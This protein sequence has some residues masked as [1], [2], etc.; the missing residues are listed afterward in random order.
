MRM[1]KFYLLILIISLIINKVSGQNVTYTSLNDNV[2]LVRTLNLKTVGSTSGSADVSATGASSYT[3]PIAIPPGTNGIAPSVSLEYNSQSGNGILGMGWG[4]SGLSIIARQTKTIYH[5]GETNPI[6]LNASDRFAMDGAKLFFKAGI[7]Q[8]YG[9]DGN[10]HGIESENFVNVISHGTAGTGPQWFEAQTIDGSFMEFGNTANSSIQSSTGTILAWGISKIRYTDGNYIQFVY[11]NDPQSLRITEI[12]Y[13]GNS[14]TN[15]LPYN[16]I[17]FEYKTGRIDANNQF[18]YGITLNFQHLLDKIT[19]T[20]ELETLT[21]KTYQFAY[22]NDGVNSYLTG[23]SESGSDGTSLNSTIFKYGDKPI[24]FSPSSSAIIQN[25]EG[26][27][28][29]GDFNADGLSDLLETK[30]VVVNN[31]TYH[32]EFTI[33]AKEPTN[34]ADNLFA[35]IG[36]KV[37]PAKTTVIQKKNYP[38]STNFLAHDFNGD[39]TDDILTVKTSIFGGE[40]RLESMKVYTSYKNPSIGYPILFDSTGLNGGTGSTGKINQTTGNFVFA[41]DFNGDGIQ[42]ILTLT[43]WSDGSIGANLHSAVF[44]TT[45]FDKVATTGIVKIPIKDWSSAQQIHILDFNGDGKSDLMIIKNQEC[46]I[47]TFEE[48]TKGYPRAR[49]IFY[50][51]TSVNYQHVIYFG[52]FNGD[53]KTD[54]LARG[55]LVNNTSVPWKKIL[56]TGKGVTEQTFTFHHTPN[57]V[58]GQSDDQLTIGD[59]NGDGKSDIYH[60]WRI[61][62]TTSNLDIYYSQGNSFQFVR[63]PFSGT[64]GNTGAIGSDLNGDGRSDVINRKSYNQPFDIFYFRKEGKENL[65]EKLANGVGHITEWNYKKLTDAGTFYIQGAVSQYPVNNIQPP[66][67]AVYEFKSQN[68]IGGYST[69]QFNYEQARLQLTGKGFLGFQKVTESNLS[70]GIKTVSENQFNPTYF[71]A[72]PYQ[73]TTYLISNSSSPIKQTTF[74]YDFINLSG[75]AISNRRFW[76]RPNNIVQNNNLEGNT[77]TTTYAYETNSAPVYHGNPTRITVNNKVT[78]NDNVIETTVTNTLT[79]VIYGTPNIYKPELIT[80]TNTRS[81]QLAYTTKT[82]YAYNSLGQVTSKKN[83]EGLAAEITTTYTYTDDLGNNL[84]NITSEKV[85]AAGVEDRTTKYVYDAKGRYPESTTNALLQTSN[86]SY[87]PKWGKP[88]TISSVDGLITTY[89][90]DA[91]GRLKITSPSAATAYNITEAYVWNSSNGA[92]WYNLL[93]HPGKPDVKTWYDVLGRKIRTETE[94]YP[95]GSTIIQTQTY[96]ER[97]NINTST[98]PYKSGE[99]IITT[100][101]L[102]DSYNRPYNINKGVLGTTTIDYTYTSGNIKITSTAPTGTSSKTTDATGQVITSSDNAGTLNY[103]YYSH[104]G[105]KDVSNNGTAL[106]SSKYDDYGRH[107]ELIDANAGTT[108]YEYNSLNELIKQTSANGEIYT[109]RYDVLG[110]STERLRSGEP[111]TFYKY[112]SSGAGINQV[113][114]ITGFSGN[115]EDYIYDGYG[116]FQSITETI[117]GSPYIRSFGYNNY[118]DVISTTYP[119]GFGTVHAYDDNGYPTTIK[120]NKPSPTTLYSTE[121][122]NGQGQVSSYSLGNG[123][124]S[125]IIYTNGFP[126]QYL[127]T[128]KQNLNLDWNYQ[129]GNLTS[130]NDAIK[131]LTENFTYDALNRL[132]TTKIG[133]TTLTTNYAANGNITTKPDAGSYSYHTTKFNAVVGVTNPSPSP[134]PLLQQDITYTAFMQPEKVTE[135]G[136]ELTYTYG[137]DYERIKNVTK[138]DNNIINTRYYFDGFEKDVTINTTQYVQYVNSPVGLIC[139]VLNDGSDLSS[140]KYIYNDHLGSILTV[141]D[142][143]GTIITSA[144]QSFDAWGRRRDPNTW[145]LL[146]PTAANALPNWLYRGYTG[147]EHLDNFGLINMNGRMYDPVVGRMLSPDT[148]IQE[149]GMTQSYNRYSYGMNNP[150]I[151]TDPDGHF[152]HIVIGAAVGGVVNLGVKA[153]HGKIHKPKDAFVAFGIGAVAGAVTAA[154]GGAAA[155]ALNL[156]V[157]SIGGGAVAGAAG[158]AT[159]GLIQGVGNA[160]Y[161][162]DKYTPKDW[163]IGIGVGAAA[164]GLGGGIAAWRNGVKT[165]IPKNLW[166]GDDVADGRNI[167]GGFKRIKPEYGNGF[168]SGGNLERVIDPDAISEL[169]TNNNVFASKDNPIYKATVDKYLSEMTDNTFDPVKNAVGGFKAG[170]DFIIREGHHRV[171]AAIIYGMKTNDYSILTQL[172]KQGK[173]TPYTSAYGA[174]NKIKFPTIWK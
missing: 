38:E 29:V 144:Q 161:F 83:F 99:A 52:D 62:S 100:T 106:S 9:G 78:A 31:I 104:G 12:N 85:S 112:F 151:N 159:G 155:G 101:T 156:S 72:S 89:Q 2:S 145:T 110:R 148:Y 68:G 60:G 95:L 141:T 56:S 87:D 98:K 1:K 47:F 140:Y 23:V 70:S 135:N 73:T 139:I 132:E 109:M 39:G 107:I 143:S 169:A 41:G 124:S 10:W 133:T 115:T 45:F 166:N 88:L 8:V 32:T 14:V 152:W 5:D 116:R 75:T 27:E 36:Y 103:S 90:Y 102:Y 160:V 54:M 108:K 164:G 129:T 153:F 134:I 19:V 69:V 33:Y 13:T 86:S 119:S 51:T 76:F 82:K 48:G 130:R 122:V 128:G 170:E 37:L 79:T 30:K 15:L 63:N 121:G 46:E 91:Y 172:I 11:A 96:D 25:V 150:M 171:T 66:L 138:K 18:E 77:V 165:R 123:Q 120:N 174:L 157:A 4:L 158:S 92:V 136:F 93:S 28:Y 43:G 44:N 162:K 84:G 94:G 97:G 58:G 3:I 35:S 125:S 126:T 146:S 34:P 55:S 127:T 59:F 17:K 118:G 20:T 131:S 49:S 40:W 67:Y 61:T 114:K 16:K 26:D 64:I 7:T 173:F 137:A 117:D 147:H 22:G 50:S 21:V 80:I 74:S 6:E 111:T 53:K 65:L 105:L 154:T 81:G 142:N 57:I 113:E 163:L 42:D 24:E 168:G 167:W 149:P 71:D